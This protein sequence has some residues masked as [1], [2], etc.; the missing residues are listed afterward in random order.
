MAQFLL[1]RPR[2]SDCPK[3]RGD[4]RS[5]ALDA[6]VPEPSEH[7]PNTPDAPI[8]IH[9]IRAIFMEIGAFFPNILCFGIVYR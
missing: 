9:Q 3:I 1:K 2:K 5:K 4:Q 7:T 8:E 6:Q